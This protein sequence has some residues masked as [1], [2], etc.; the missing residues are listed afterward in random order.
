MNL[1][2]VAL[3]ALCIVSLFLSPALSLLIGMVFALSCGAVLEKRTA[4]SSSLLLKVAV[5]GLG[6]GI[7]IEESL[8]TSSEGIVLTV[9]SIFLVMVAGYGLAKVFKIGSKLAYLISSGTAICGGSAI[10]A[11]A[12]VIK[13]KAQDT[14]MALAV[15]FSLNAVA[16]LTFPSI[17]RY[18]NLSQAD[19]GMW[20]ALAIHDTSA[21]VGAAKSYGAEALDIAVLVKLSRALWI[22]PLSLISIFLFK[23]TDSEGK[24]GVSIPWFILLFIVAMVIN[25]YIALPQ[26][27]TASVEVS[28]HHILSLCLFLI[29]SQLSVDAVKRAGIKS[30]LFG[31]S[32]WVFISVGSL[33]II[34]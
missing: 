4:K 15:V 7:N 30:I 31:I 8:R 20:A 12:P 6:F 17:G 22:I 5:V 1:K 14:S 27:F 18:L 23:S 2:V 26:W 16:M 29:G 28:S 32:L 25:S 3:L 34:V 24:R 33:L 19:F 21:V 10:A 11:V 9:V 13:S